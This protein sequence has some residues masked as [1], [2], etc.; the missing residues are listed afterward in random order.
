MAKRSSE[1]SQ[2]E[3][4]KNM[5]SEDIKNRQWTENERHALRRIS[6]RQAAMDDSHIDLTDIPRLTDEQLANMVRLREVRPSKVPVSVR[7]DPLV[8]DWLRSKGKGHLSRIND[9]LMNLM[10]AEQR[11]QPRR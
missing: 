1:S 6:V 4:L 8:L 9:I 11:K 5:K 10:E 2:P 3:R 7:L